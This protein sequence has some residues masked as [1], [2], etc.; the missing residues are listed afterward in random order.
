MENPCSLCSKVYKQKHNL[1]K[2]IRVAHKLYPCSV[3]LDTFDSDNN[4]R[5]HRIEAHNKCVNCNRVVLNNCARHIELCDKKI[6][7]EFTFEDGC[8][9]KTSLLTTLQFC[10]LPV[11]WILCRQVRFAKYNTNEA[12]DVVESGK[13]NPIFTCKMTLSLDKNNLASQ[14]DDNINK[15]LE[16][17]DAY[18]REGSGWQYVCTDFWLLKVYRYRPTHPKSYIPTPK[19]LM[20]KRAILNIKNT[21]NKCFLWS[22]LAAL[23]PVH[24]RDAAY[25]VEKYVKYERELNMSGIDFPVGLKDIQKFEALNNISINVYTYRNKKIYPLSITESERGFHV[26]LLIL[27]KSNK[28]HYCLIRDFDRLC[29]NSNRRATKKYFCPF[30]IRPQYNQ[31]KLNLHLELCRKHQPTRISLA[32]HKTLGFTNYRFNLKVPYVIYGDFECF[33]TREA[34]HVPCGYC[35]VVVNEESAILRTITYSGEDVMKHF[36]RTL[37]QLEVDIKN[38]RDA[39]NLYTHE[40]IMTDEDVVRYQNAEVCHICKK[41]FD[42]G[43]EDDDDDEHP[44]PKRR[45]R[46]HDHKTGAFRGAAHSVCNVNY[47]VSEKIPVIFHNLKNYDGHLIVQELGKYVGKKRISVIAKDMEKYMT[48]SIGK[49]QFLDSY[50]FLSASLSSLAKTLT[51]FKYVDDPLLQMKGVYPYEHMQSRINFSEKS[52]P[53]I[54]KFY[55]TLRGKGIKPEKYQHALNVWQHFKI[56]NM[57]QYH[58][59]Y[60]ETDTKLLAEVFETFRALSLKDYD[61]DPCHVLSLPGLTWQAMLKFTGVEM[62]LIRDET[63]HLLIEEGIRGG[64]S[65]I[66]TKYSKANNKYMSEYDPNQE[67]KYIIYLDCNALYSTAMMEPMPHSNFKWSNY[68]AYLNNTDENIGFILQVELEYPAELHDL[69]NDLPLAPERLRGKLIPNLNNKKDYVLHYKALN[70][71]LALGM[72]VSKVRKVLQFTQSRW[73]EPYILFNIQKRMA[74][75]TTFE[76]KF[77]KDLNNSLFGKTIENQRKYSNIKLVIGE[78]LK[79]LV[80]SPAFVN[81]KAFDNELHAVQ[82]MKTSIVLN[83]P[84]YLGMSILDISKVIMYDFHYGYMAKFPDKKLLFTDTDSLMYEIKTE[85]FYKEIAP[86]VELH[87]DT[88]S[89]PKEHFLY[90]S[91][92][93]KVAGMFKDEAS[94]KIIAE[95]IGLRPKLYSYVMDSWLNAADETRVKLEK[96]TKRA[97]GTDAA[98]RKY[99]LRHEDYRNCLTSREEFVAPVTRIVH[100]LHCLTTRVS[101]KVVLSFHDDKRI[102]KDDYHTLAY[103]HYSVMDV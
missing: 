56:K 8:D 73:L 61:I 24:W 18:Q 57:Q 34:K 102:L 86:D 90:R 40:I 25:R 48:F 26:N 66:T 94:G 83:K 22:I 103:G 60:L 27:T 74:A 97:K 6:Y 47:R 88:A 68:D 44:S 11:K 81:S 15:I 53:P 17:M 98:T 51:S 69:H 59:L 43:E 67:S 96:N 10:P 76:K 9:I 38:L 30:C 16:S 41:P 37:F 1:C 31:F 92:N 71:Y 42:D 65:M 45:V 54:D 28:H 85:D 19:E 36:F 58:D 84:K 3:C 21:D 77:Y 39:G 95:F 12:G 2:H 23:H 50:N 33:I 78:K 13:S 63:M 101:P 91:V 80:V 14:I 32:H 29:S 82:M 93:N 64:V 55:S 62:D 49:L 75:E 70:K 46:D 5:L 79:K 100:K 4:M 89:Y 7:K 87:F 20:P 99:I 52:L 35:L 72:K